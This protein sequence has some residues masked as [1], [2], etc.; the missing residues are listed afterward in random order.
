MTDRFGK[1]QD[2]SWYGSAYFLTLRA[3]QSQWGKVYKY[4]PLKT[5][6]LV[7]ICIFE[8]G[9]LISAIAP[10]STTVIV[11]RSI[12][13]LG[14]SGIAPG[15]YTI[16][17]FAAEYVITCVRRLMHCASHSRSNYRQHVLARSVA[18]WIRQLA[19]A[20]TLKHSNEH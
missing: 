16:A 2:I 19:C 17:A 13:G 18:I 20:P 6:F 5:A 12:A 11:G 4:F 10:N 1:I 15:V 7:S 3:F 14:A 9:S 8:L